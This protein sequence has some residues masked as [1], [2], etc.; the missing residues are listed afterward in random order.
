MHGLLWCQNIP[1]VDEKNL[2]IDKIEELRNY[3]DKLCYAMNP[4]QEYGE[5]HPSRIKFSDIED[6]AKEMDLIHIY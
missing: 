3:F 1:I 4:I 5:T 6:E 2:T